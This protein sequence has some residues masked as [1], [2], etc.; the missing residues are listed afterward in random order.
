MFLN[1]LFHKR[2][3]D[4]WWYELSWSHWF[5]NQL[6]MPTVFLL[7]L[8]QQIACANVMKS[9]LFGD[10]FTLSS[11]SC[12]ATSQDQECFRLGFVHYFWINANFVQVFLYVLSDC[13]DRSVGV[14][15]EYFVQFFVMINY[16]L[17]MFIEDVKS[18]LDNFLIVIRSPARLSSMQKSFD[19]FVFLAIE[20]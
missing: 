4:F 10:L 17:W 18:L 1:L 6:F 12:S 9:K 14:N 19:Q 3:D 11:L 5:I 20:V 15:S 8:S 16:W 7:L 13:V 2:N